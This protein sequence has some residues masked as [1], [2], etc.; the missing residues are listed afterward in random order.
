[1]VSFLVAKA[2]Y[3]EYG[4]M[5]D[6][7]LPRDSFVDG[8]GQVGARINQTPEIS[9]EFTLL[10]QQGSQ[11]IQGNMLVVPI[12][13]SILYVQPIYIAARS[14]GTTGGN[15]AA[16][17]EFKRVV[18]VF[19]DRIVMRDTLAEA[20]TAVFGDAPVVDDGDG[21]LPDDITEAVAELLARAEAAFAR[22]DAALRSADL[23]EYQA[24]V[25]EAQSL[26]T[27]AQELLEDVLS[28]ES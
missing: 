12:E 27:Q 3:D 15:V 11:V 7:E 13:E 9:Q 17:P 8:P 18:V 28:P 26:I 4:A 22:A 21:E 10:D 19:G 24:A 16:L 14:G 5:I 2:D 1:M 20:L 25:A 23:A 6:F